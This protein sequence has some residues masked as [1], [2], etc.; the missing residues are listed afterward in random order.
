MWGVELNPSHSGLEIESIVGF[1]RQETL[2]C[3]EFAV[4]LVIRV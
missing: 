4:S 3:R 2:V 1:G